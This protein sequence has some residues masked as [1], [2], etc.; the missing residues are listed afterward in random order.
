MA[1]FTCPPERREGLDTVK[2]AVGVTHNYL[3]G[4]IYLFFE[5]KKFDV[6][7]TVAKLE[8]RDVM[9]K[10]VFAKYEITPSLR[11]SMRAGIVQY[12]GRDKEGRAVLFFNT[13]RD[14]PKADQRPERQ[15]NMDMFLSWAVRCDPANPTSTVTWLI[16]QQDASLMKHTDLIF[17]KDM[18]L[19]ISKFFPGVVAKMYICNMGSA[20][21]FV[22]RPL[23]KQLPKAISDCIFL[24]SAGD[25]R[26]G[27][28][29]EVMDASVLPVSMGGDNDID[30]QDNYE[31]FATAIESYFGRCQNAL[32]Q[33]LSSIKEM[34]M[35]E[36]FPVDKNGA[37]LAAP[38]GPPSGAP[39]AAV[40]ARGRPS[41]GMPDAL[42]STVG[43]QRRIEAAAE[44][45]LD[46]A[47]P[48]TRSPSKICVNRDSTESILISS[49]TLRPIQ[50][51]DTPPV[52]AGQGLALSLHN[53]QTDI[54]WLPAAQLDA[55]G[56]PA[57][58]FE[59]AAAPFSFAQLTPMMPR[60]TQDQVAALQRS[61]AQFL[62]SAAKLQPLLLRL[63]EAL[64]DDD[65]SDDEVAHL[66][67]DA[68][69]LRRV[70]HHVLDLSPQTSEPLRYPI[71]RW[72]DAGL[73][74]RRST[75]THQTLADRLVS[76]ATS[77]DNFLLAL[78]AGSAE[79][80][81][82]C[83]GLL[84]VDKVKDRILRRV[85]L[86]WP[87]NV[88]YTAVLAGLRAKAADLWSRAVPL[89]RAYIETKVAMSV[90]EFIAHHG[91]L[92]NGGRMDTGSSW[93]AKLCSG[94]M[95]HREMRRNNWLFYVFPPMFA[96]EV[97]TASGEPPSIADML[98]AATRYDTTVGP[99][100]VNLAT[101]SEFL[102]TVE[103][104][105]AAT[106]EQ[107]G[108]SSV[109]RIVSHAA[110][111]NYMEETGTKVYIPY[112]S[113]LK[114]SK[115]YDQIA[116]ERNCA[117]QVLEALEPPLKELL[118]T[119]S[120]LLVFEHRGVIAG[121]TDGVGETD[122]PIARDDLLQRVG[123]ARRQC[124]D[125]VDSRR[126]ARRIGLSLTK[127]AYDTQG[128]FGEDTYGVIPVYGPLSADTD[129][130]MTVHPDGYA[131]ALNLLVAEALVNIR[132]DA[133]QHHSPVNESFA[134]S[135]ENMSRERAPNGS[136]LPLP[137]SSDN[138]DDDDGMRSAC[139]RE[140]VDITTFIELAAS[141]DAAAVPLVTTKCLL[142]T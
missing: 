30:N 98:R 57:L 36:S 72:L 99:T 22:M 114:G 48:L 11:Q 47:S 123:G 100:P 141:M 91:L 102:I 78:Q 43:R 136:S 28:L 2:R 92:A 135:I 77:P 5:N 38:G 132:F 62:S 133:Q 90:G 139:S 105:L 46:L 117:R 37:P 134:F 108:P 49:R 94:L 61:W 131:L 142:S 64:R 4:W 53:S 31:L 125:V 73:D 96:Q 68:V 66:A 52:S 8:R 93:Y 127:A 130:C 3:D 12:I 58:R 33:G 140:E 74:Q 97:T 59:P 35:M 126:T 19:R 95:Q 69:L 122:G 103:R 65:L 14:S 84:E 9:E 111:E 82:E 80:V 138:A 112:E 29:L 124:F 51:G 110:V 106:K 70:T 109:T 44:E 107:L 121:G 56:L 23:L 75:K 20:L 88:A 83:D 27:K 42:C 67:E 45:M 10:T 32:R 116:A 1:L 87:V 16:N 41:E 81:D 40:A 39:D 60:L 89:F 115:P 7:E 18:A 26:R 128:T 17:Q 55:A 13:A 24:F 86:S 15:A 54:A 25:I 21:A 104:C 137:A 76:D 113:Q 6:R 71:F 129:C 120:I 119:L 50:G 118:L 85:T 101:V 63:M 79:Y 34:E